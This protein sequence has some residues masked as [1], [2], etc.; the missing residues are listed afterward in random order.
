[1]E[2]W[3][4]TQNERALIKVTNV[5]LV[6]GGRI[7]TF[8]NEYKSNGCFTLGYYKE[9][10]ALKILDEIQK[11]MT[12][13]FL[14]KEKEHINYGNMEDLRKYYR[15]KEINFVEV[16]NGIELEP[17]NKDILVYEMPLQ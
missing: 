3:I 15:R 7:V 4:K 17:I 10:R 11:K 1:M 13:T 16:P 2:L 12:Q 8:G 5:A 14:L 9:E 6:S